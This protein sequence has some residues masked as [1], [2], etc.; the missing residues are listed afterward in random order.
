[1]DHLKSF[2]ANVQSTLTDYR[3][4]LAHDREDELVSKILGTLGAVKRAESSAG[5]SLQSSMVKEMAESFK[6]KVLFSI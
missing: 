1:M 5:A 3:G 4:A 6:S 2:K